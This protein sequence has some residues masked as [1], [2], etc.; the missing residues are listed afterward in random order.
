MTRSNLIL[1][2]TLNVIDDYRQQIGGDD[3]RL[4]IHDSL[5]AF[6]IT[7]MILEKVNSAISEHNQHVDKDKGEKGW[8]LITDL[9]VYVVAEVMLG[10]YPICNICYVNSKSDKTNSILSI[11]EDEGL[12][13]GLYTSDEGVFLELAQQY[14]PEIADNAGFEKLMKI[15]HLK[16]DVK[17]PNH[18]ADLAAAN[19]GIVDIP[20]KK[21][22]PFSYEYVFVAKSAGNY[23]EDKSQLKCPVFVNPDGTTWDFDE[24]LDDLTDDAEVRPLFREIIG[25]TLRPNVSYNK[26]AFFYAETGNNGKGTFCELIKALNPNF[27]A[28]PI[29]K[30]DDEFALTDAPYTNVIIGDDNDVG[31]LIQRSGNF[32][33]T[34]TNDSIPVNR[35]HR[36][37]VSAVIRAFM[38]QC[39]NQLP[40]FKDKTTA[41][42]RRIIIVPFDKCFT[43]IERG[44]IKT[45]YM[46]RQ[47]VLD[48]A[49]TTA[50]DIDC[51]KLSEPKNCKMMLAE[52]TVINDPIKQFLEEMLDQFSWD[53]VPFGFL[54]SLYVKWYALNIPTGSTESS[55]SFA[56]RVRNLILSSPDTYYEWTMTGPNGTKVA[57]RM[58]NPEML[59][60]TYDIKGWMRQNYHGNDLRTICTPNFD[61]TKQ[62]FKGLVRKSSMTI[63]DEEKEGE[64]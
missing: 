25:A 51:R 43:G 14:R 53:L 18:D 2:E 22:L 20:N 34:I 63:D 29:D 62:V 55:K 36:D 35:K 32:K 26:T 9:P 59:I 40:R 57:H 31:V 1:N 28:L 5:A 16:A 17:N 4:S 12:K 42:Y 39:F 7:S 15:L 38:I 24:W 37:Q 45:D 27:I 52:Y 11:Y 41:L 46:H 61:K 19:N 58:D 47:E 48:Y 8:A 21:L 10:L 56:G 13:Q 54:Y 3:A 6:D 23:I 44:Y 64:E 33:N 49:L 50:L 30:F 60:A